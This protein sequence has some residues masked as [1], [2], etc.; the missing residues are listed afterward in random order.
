MWPGWLLEPPLGKPKLLL[1][2]LLFILLISSI[3]CFKQ[4][5]FFFSSPFFN[6]VLNSVLLKSFPANFGG[7]MS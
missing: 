7:D 6:D 5:L 1:F 2:Q 3:S 4:K